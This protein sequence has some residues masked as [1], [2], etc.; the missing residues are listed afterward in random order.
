MEF[1]SL[2][3]KELYLVAKTNELDLIKDI[4]NQI[5]AKETLIQN[6]IKNFLFDIIRNNVS[7]T[8]TQNNLLNTLITR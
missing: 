3:K 2:H 5:I 1:I 8:T 6:Q 4:V 7:F